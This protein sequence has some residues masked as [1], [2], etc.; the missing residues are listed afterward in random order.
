M[1]TDMLRRLTN[2]RI[3]TIIISIS[4]IIIINRGCSAP[5]HWCVFTTDHRRQRSHNL[6]NICV[7]IHVGS[8]LK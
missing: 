5:G 8:V 1:S 2:C 4:I 6:F 7:V 3:I